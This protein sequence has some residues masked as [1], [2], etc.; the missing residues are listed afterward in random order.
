MYQY[1][2]TGGNINMSLI[3]LFNNKCPS[4]GLATRIFA[5]P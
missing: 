2:E 5:F 3:E 1:H 4:S